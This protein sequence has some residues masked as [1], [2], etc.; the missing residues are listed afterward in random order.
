MSKQDPLLEA[1]E[2]CEGAILDAIACEDGLDGAAGYRVLMMIWP[3]L[4]KHGLTS[5]IAPHTRVTLAGM[6][7]HPIKWR[8]AKPVSI[9]NRE[10]RAIVAKL[11][12]WIQRIESAN[13]ALGN[14]VHAGLFRQDISEVT[15]EMKQAAAEKAE[16][17]ART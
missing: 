8:I 10:L 17:K 2:F 16:P 4:E 14:T 9:E 3:V 5:C 11:P 12:V 13:E 15:K 1:L 7:G 6:Y